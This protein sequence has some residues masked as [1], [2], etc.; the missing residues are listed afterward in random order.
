M[1]GLY[2]TVPRS[3]RRG[4]PHL[5]DDYDPIDGPHLMPCPL[6]K[7]DWGIIVMISGVFGAVCLVAGKLWGEK[8]GPA[9][10]W[11]EPTEPPDLPE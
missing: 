3:K 7:P 6:P 5:R 11:M 4:I 2:G 10:S 8:T 1:L 9:Q